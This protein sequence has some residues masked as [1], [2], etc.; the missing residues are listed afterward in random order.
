MGRSAANEESLTNADSALK[1]GAQKHKKA[2]SYDL[3][4]AEAE[5][6]DP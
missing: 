5:G 4:L 3:Q 1:Q 2:T 6:K